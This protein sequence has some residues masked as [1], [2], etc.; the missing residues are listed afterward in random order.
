MFRG[1]TLDAAALL[2]LLLLPPLIK[3][4]LSGAGALPAEMMTGVVTPMGDLS[5]IARIVW[6]FQGLLPAVLLA[7]LLQYAALST[8]AWWFIGVML[9]LALFRIK[10]LSDI[11]RLGRRK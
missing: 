1:T 10:Q 4:S 5:A 6:M 7:V 2:I 11:E 9:L 3:L 8:A